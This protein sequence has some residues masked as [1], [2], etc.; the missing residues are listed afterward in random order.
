MVEGEFHLPF[1][2]TSDHLN[3]LTISCHLE[4][5]STSPSDPHTPSSPI[6]ECPFH[7]VKRGRDRV[8][9]RT[10]TITHTTR[11]SYG[12]LRRGKTKK[13][14]TRNS[15]TWTSGG[16]SPVTSG[17]VGRNI[18]RNPTYLTRTPRRPGRLVFGKDPFGKCLVT[19]TT[20]SIRRT[21]TGPERCWREGRTE[22]P[23]RPR[24]VWRD[25]ITS[26]LSSINQKGSFHTRWKAG[27]F[28]DW[29][30]CGWGSIFLYLKYTRNLYYYEDTAVTL[31]SSGDLFFTC[32]GP[33]FS[34]NQSRPPD[35]RPPV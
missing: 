8:N 35:P 19:P 24:T 7:S 21:L 5:T 6:W 25:T 31:L 17:R 30:F 33:S 11:S 16:F 18:R 27:F 23:T 2:T 28:G 22:S 26:P 1:T 29:S 14:P 32:K 4:N 15:G 13:S 3:L 10:G 20:P 34:L 9:V 12:V